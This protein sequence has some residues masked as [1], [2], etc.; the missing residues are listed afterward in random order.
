MSKL[1]SAA[2]LVGATATAASCYP[3]RLDSVDYDVVATVFDSSA[4][5]QANTFYLL[6]Q[7]VH[8]VPPGEADNLPAFNEAAVLAQIRTNMTS[9]G[10]TEVTD[11]NA[12]DIR[13]VSAVSTTEYQGYYWDYWCYTWY[14]YCPPYWGVYE[15]TVGSIFVTMKDRRAQGASGTPPMW[16]GIGNGLAGSGATT[17]R[18]SDAIDQMFAQSPY[19][20]AN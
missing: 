10:Y 7:V 9:R 11:S 5:F 1:L 18:L 12:A 16:L 8:L 6:D 2:L 15:F 20:D 17:Q 4:N 3:N 13:M 14:Y 19:I